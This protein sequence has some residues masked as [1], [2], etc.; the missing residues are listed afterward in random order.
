MPGPQL[1]DRL[2][3]SRLLWT[4]PFQATSLWSRKPFLSSQATLQLGLFSYISSLFFHQNPRVFF[5]FWTWPLNH[6]FYTVG[7]NIIIYL[8]YIN[9]PFL[10]IAIYGKTFLR[11]NQ[12]SKGPAKRWSSH[13]KW[14]TSEKTMH[15]ESRQRQKAQAIKAKKNCQMAK[16]GNLWQT[17]IAIENYTIYRYL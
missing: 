14:R 7:F 2:D 12:R 3:Q 9:H 4:I 15:L 13:Y 6:R 11:K 17:N 1:E 5:R 10:G 8:L 16:S